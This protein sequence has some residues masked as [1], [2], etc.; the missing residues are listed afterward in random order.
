MKQDANYL[1]NAIG[2]IFSAIQ[3]NEVLS[4]VSWG[5]TL[6]ATILS[7]SFTIYRWYKKAKE[8]GKIDKKELEELGDIVSD[9]TEEI[10]EKSKHD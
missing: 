4:W 8:D 9:A 3:T 7:I 5:I 1:F 2:V 6:L 10:K